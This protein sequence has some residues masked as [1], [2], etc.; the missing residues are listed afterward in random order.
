MVQNVLEVESCSEAVE[1]ESKL[2]T[3]EIAS[4]MLIKHLSYSKTLKNC[5]DGAGHPG[6]HRPDAKMESNLR[7]W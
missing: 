6:I 1:V 7:F 3:P 5:F 2:D 4:L